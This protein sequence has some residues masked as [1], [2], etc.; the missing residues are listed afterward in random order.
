MSAFRTLFK[1]FPKT[2]IYIGGTVLACGYDTS[3][4]MYKHCSRKDTPKEFAEK[5]NMLCEYRHRDWPLML[6]K[7]GYDRANGI[8]HC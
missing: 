5:N 1:E 7:Y 4:N 8:E 2:T 3:K 6:T